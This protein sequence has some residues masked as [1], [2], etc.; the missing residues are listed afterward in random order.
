MSH[1]ILKKKGCFGLYHYGN[2]GFY[3][4]FKFH[5][6]FFSPLRFGTKGARRNRTRTGRL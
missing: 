6:F 3:G 1:E 4:S 5:F 2:G